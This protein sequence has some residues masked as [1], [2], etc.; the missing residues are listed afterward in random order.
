MVIDKQTWQEILHFLF[1]PSVSV[2]DIPYPTVDL[3]P[4]IS[5]FPSWFMFSILWGIYTN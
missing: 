5:E 3:F 1:F 4:A 2:W